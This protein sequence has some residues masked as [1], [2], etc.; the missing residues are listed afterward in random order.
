MKWY[1][2]SI[3]HFKIPR[4]G[5]TFKFPH[6]VSWKILTFDGHPPYKSVNL[7]SRCIWYS[8]RELKLHQSFSFSV[9]LG[10]NALNSNHSWPTGSFVNG[11]ISCEGFSVHH[12]HLLFAQRPSI[13]LLL[14]P[15]RMSSQAY[16]YTFLFIPSW[17]HSFCF[18]SNF[19]ILSSFY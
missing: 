13:I 9:N 11:K 7:V 10:R 4:R 19:F 14:W 12:I 16:N 18:G 3:K 17:P 8:V 1:Q 5:W 6:S 15:Q 2:D